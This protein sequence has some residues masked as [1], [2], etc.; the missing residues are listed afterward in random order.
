M[1]DPYLDLVPAPKLK[2]NK[3]KRD[4]RRK[5]TAQDDPSTST[6]TTLN[7]NAPPTPTTTTTITTNHG[8]HKRWPQKD[9]PHFAMTQKFVPSQAWLPEQHVATKDEQAQP[10]KDPSPPPPAAGPVEALPSPPRAEPTPLEPSTRRTPPDITLLDPHLDDSSDDELVRQTLIPIPD[11]IPATA[12]SSRSPTKEPQLQ[13]QP[14]SEDMDISSDDLPAELSHLEEHARILNA[15]DSSRSPTPESEPT[16][17]VDQYPHSPASRDDDDEDDEENSHSPLP[18]SDDSD[19]DVFIYDP[20]DGTHSHLDSVSARSRRFQDIIDLVDVSD[21]ESYL[22]DSSDDEDHD[23]EMIIVEQPDSTPS[24]ASAPVPNDP[25]ASTHFPPLTSA[26][27]L[28]ARARGKRPL[29]PS[30]DTEVKRAKR[31]TRDPPSLVTLPDTPVVSASTSTYSFQPLRTRPT[32]GALYPLRRPI[33]LPFLDLSSPS[34]SPSDL[35]STHVPLHHRVRVIRRARSA[36]AVP[37]DVPDPTSEGEEGEVATSPARS[38]HPTTAIDPETG[39]LVNPSTGKGVYVR[40]RPSLAPSTPIA[41]GAS[42]LKFLKRQ[43]RSSDVTPSSPSTTLAPP[44]SLHR[45]AFDRR[46][47]AHRKLRKWFPAE[48]GPVLQEAFFR[49][50]SC[51]ALSSEALKQSLPYRSIGYGFW[52][53]AIPTPTPTALL[54]AS[55]PIPTSTTAGGLNLRPRVDIFVDNSNIIHSFHRWL[56]QTFPP[57][58]VSLASRLARRVQ[59]DVID[60]TRYYLDYD[61]LFALLERGMGSRVKKRVLVGSSLLKQGVEDAVKWGYEVSILQ[62]V[63]RRS[64][65]SSDPDGPITTLQKEQA[66]DELLHLKMLEAILEHQSTPHQPPITTTSTSSSSPRPLMILVSGDAKSSEYNP[67]G[68]LGCVR[69]ALAHNWDIEIWAFKKS[70]NRFWG[71]LSREQG[72][73][74]GIDGEEVWGCGDVR[75]VDLSTWAGELVR[76]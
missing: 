17:I 55:L 57:K 69:H 14:V 25:F 67:S 66:V 34:Q 74:R 27:S 64:V 23:D 30:S 15:D 40:S 76:R 52:P 12:E 13:A 9:K 61:I 26:T 75:L 65:L 10:S 22:Y 4:K 16:V 43:L 32:V 72:R 35:A 41:I 59:E 5:S 39:I 33:P 46:L 45:T 11:T 58:N 28:C 48:V 31:A 21:G 49:P 24:I 2:K 47:S 8:Q 54:T 6:S 7:L 29:D 73:K 70:T 62:R 63:P 56:G 3:R 19:Q 38:P 1:A 18:S 44:P 60:G 68:F 50:S 71:D 53:G 36:S 20:R 51:M 37:V 42:R